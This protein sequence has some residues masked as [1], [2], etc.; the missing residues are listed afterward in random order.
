MYF[1][2]LSYK[3]VLNMKVIDFEILYQAITAIEAQEA[4]L[5]LEVSDYPHLK[6]NARKKVYKR[7]QKLA[8]PAQK[9]EKALSMEEVSRILQGSL[10]GRY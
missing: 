1:Y 5:M 2:N 6:P 4:L 9:E 3:E 7:L 8:Y 10:S